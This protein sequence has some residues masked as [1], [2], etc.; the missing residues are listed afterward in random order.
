MKIQG[1]QAGYTMR[2]QRVR[3]FKLSKRTKDEHRKEKS[4]QQQRNIYTI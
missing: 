4:E 2:I 1:K 3:R